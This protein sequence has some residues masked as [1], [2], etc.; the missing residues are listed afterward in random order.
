MWNSFSIRYI[1]ENRTASL[2]LSGAVFL[3]SM[4][5]S[6]MTALAY[7]LWTDHVKQETAKGV[8]KVESTA[9]FVVY[10]VILVVMCAALIAM[11]HNAFAV[12]MQSRLHQLG[13]LKSVGAT[14]RQIRVGLMRETAQ[15]G[16]RMQQTGQSQCVF[17][18]IR[19]TFKGSCEMPQRRR[20]D[21]LW[22]R[23]NV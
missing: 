19:F 7:N 13:I 15:R 11:I 6:L 10:A 2:L 22:R 23:R 21:Q 3:A 4:L 16:G 1:K 20:G 14:P 18:R 5:L 12:S 9:L 8:T 17:L